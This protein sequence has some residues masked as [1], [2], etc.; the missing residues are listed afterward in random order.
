M[1][2]KGHFDWE[3]QPG[4][5]RAKQTGWA[6]TRGTERVWSFD[7]EGRPLGLFEAG[8]FYQRGL[9]NRWLHKFRNAQGR[10]RT[11]LDSDR[12]EGLQT[13]L[14]RQLQALS[15]HFPETLQALLLRWSPTALAAEAQ[16]FAQVY[17]PLSILP[18]DQYL[19]IVTQLAEGCSYNRCSF[20]NFYKDRPFRIKS[21]AEFAEH[22]KAVAQL[23]G[24]GSSLRKGIFLADGDALMVPQ[25]RLLQALGQIRQYW[26]TL[27]IYSF[28]DAFRPQAKSQAQLAALRAEGLERV[29]LGIESGDAELLAFL[30]KPGSPGIMQAECQKM[31]A[32][33]LSLGL[34]LMVGVGGENF[35]V[36]HRQASL[37][38]LKTLPLDS[39]D[40]IFL[41]E[42]VPHPDQPYVSKAMAKGIRPLSSAELQHEL[43]QWRSALSALPARIVPYHLQEFIY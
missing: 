43:A 9:D 11:V 27:P 2:S 36:Q 24:A 21:Q 17:R 28:M 40:R 37:N 16:R 41:S 42:F 39:H 7:S 26:P 25:A 5:W 15:P 31:K 6:L 10:Q 8:D 33:G 38:W 30:E 32:A 14:F 29:Y 13:Q 34:I 12:T 22:L 4:T 18:P 23:L 3:G 19:A 35:A 20:C 1:A